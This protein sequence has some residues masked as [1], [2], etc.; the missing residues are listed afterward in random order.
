LLDVEIGV[1]KFEANRSA[2]FVL[3]LGLALTAV[4]GLKLF[5]VY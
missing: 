3:F 5:G 1:D 4:V 2:I